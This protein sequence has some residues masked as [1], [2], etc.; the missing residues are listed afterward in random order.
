MLLTSNTQA[1]HSHSS[2]PVGQAVAELGAKMQAFFTSSKPKLI[3]HPVGNCTTQHLRRVKHGLRPLI[4]QAFMRNLYI[5][6][7]NT[8]YTKTKHLFRIRI[9]HGSSFENKQ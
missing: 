9:I 8:A 4:T 3:S 6:A 2:F 7:T 1:L 5:V